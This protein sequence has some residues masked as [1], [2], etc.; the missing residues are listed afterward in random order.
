[1]QTTREQFNKLYHHEYKT[2]YVFSEDYSSIQN[3]N[4]LL[5]QNLSLQSIVDLIY[6]NITLAKEVAQHLIVMDEGM[7]SAEINP[8]NSMYR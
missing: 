2:D 1:M 6:S 3:M 4:H 5:I 8:E 7:N